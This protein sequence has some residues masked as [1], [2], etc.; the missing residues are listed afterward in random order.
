MT[1]TV[2][3][4]TGDRAYQH[5]SCGCV[6]GASINVGHNFVLTAV[7]GNRSFTD[8]VAGLHETTPRSVN[9]QVALTAAVTAMRA[10]GLLPDTLPEGW[11]T[12]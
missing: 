11:P 8:T 2:T 12:T 6:N 5:V 7:T 3:V 10:T 4:D 1:Q 9:K